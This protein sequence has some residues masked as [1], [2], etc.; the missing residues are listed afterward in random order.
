MIEN[1]NI[2][3]LEVTVKKI[4]ILVMFFTSLIFSQNYISLNYEKPS[5]QNVKDDYGYFNKDVNMDGISAA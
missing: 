4:A 1:F 5:S 3:K 2:L